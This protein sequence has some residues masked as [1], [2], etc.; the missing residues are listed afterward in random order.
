MKVIIY[1]ALI[2]VC[3][4]AFNHAAVINN[5][6]PDVVEFEPTYDEGALY[7]A[8]EEHLRHRRQTSNGQAKVD[9]QQNRGTTSV[10]AQVG[11][12]W[13]SKDR[14]T[15]VEANVNY[16][17]DYGSGRSK[18]NYGGNIGITHRF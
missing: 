18:P 9:V 17:R 1:S 4:A 11:R 3:I 15:R 7:D 5:Q 10:N 6:I 14:N 13:E 12:V 8:I 2:V 16:G